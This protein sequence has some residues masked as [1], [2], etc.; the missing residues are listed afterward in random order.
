MTDSWEHDRNLLTGVLALQMGH[1]SRDELLK[2][3]VVWSG[4]RPRP[5][6]AILIE[7]GALQPDKLPS[8]VEA[9]D[10]LMGQNRDDRARI[11][12]TLNYEVVESI[13]EVL[14]TVV[15]P[16]LQA[17]LTRL[18]QR[19]DDTSAKDM[20]ATT[21][22][23]PGTTERNGPST[24]NQNAGPS[25]E[26]RCRFE[27]RSLLKR[28]G[29]GEVY[30]AFDHELGR[31]VALKEIQP[32]KA[33]GTRARDRFI[34]ESEICA[35]LEHPNIVPVYGRGAYPDGTLYYAMRFV[36]GEELQD[37]LDRFHREA[38]GKTPAWWLAEVRPLL[39]SFVQVCEA[40]QYAHS[41][42]VL[43][44]DLKP[45]NVL[46]A[47]FGETLII[48]WGLAKIRGHADLP[49]DTPASEGQ[50]GDSHASSTHVEN[51][52]VLQSSTAALT[53]TEDGELLGSPPYMSPE[54]ALGHHDQLTSATDIYSLGVTLYTVLV[55]HQAF[56]GKN[57][58]EVQ[59]LVARGEYKQAR[60][61]NPLVPKALSEICRKAMAMRPEDRYPT[62]QALARDIE[63]WLGDQP[64]SVH[65]DPFSTKALRWA[66]HHKMATGGSLA[67][68]V[69]VFIALLVAN[70]FVGQ[71]KTRAERARDR[72]LVARNLAGGSAELGLDVVDQLVTLGDRQLINQVPINQ[73]EGFLTKAVS[74]LK[75]YRAFEPTGHES[76]IKTALVA[77]RLANLYRLSGQ[78]DLAQPLY[79]QDVQICEDLVERDPRSARYRD[80][81]A[82]ALLEQAEAHNLA[83]KLEEADREAT[84]A[85]GLA[86]ADLRAD[87]GNSA[88]VRTAARALKQLAA[89]A[90]K[91]SPAK[92]ASLAAEAEATLGPLARTEGGDLRAKTQ[93]SQNLPLVD[94]LILVATRVLRATALES[95]GYLTEAEKELGEA[96][97][98]I[99]GVADDLKGLNIGDVA[100]QR[101]RVASARG[102]LLT[103]MGQAKEAV[104]LLDEAVEGLEGLVAKGGLP[105]H[106][107]GAA[108]AY[109]QR[110]QA[111]LKTGDIEGA[112]ADLKT[113]EDQ[114]TAMCRN[115]AKAIEPRLLL[116]SVLEVIADQTDERDQARERLSEALVAL[117]EVVR[118]SPDLKIARERCAAIEAK[119]G[120]K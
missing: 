45:S 120:P 99:D 44:R 51:P 39:R 73:R 10:R 3:L 29:L 20:A 9:V 69:T 41:R 95:D 117:S 104:I 30:L 101:A 97:S 79:E 98:L 91:V 18:S 114:L 43:H 6:S 103:E 57:R 22:W 40:I 13:Q 72:A 92:A 2:S 113:A 94:Q 7:Q 60:E 37:A 109:F 21:A 119:I 35:N 34:R 55:G 15:D 26:S 74:F 56:R 70:Y 42:D 85:L 8:I 100:F 5:L 27:K 53:R 14:R 88:P 108:E 50:A 17:D 75:S 83:G 58:P 38:K 25:T 16:E 49:S 4:D 66:R 23:G 102:R 32:A 111:R 105:S 24:A 36:L 31:E 77:R 33:G 90:L 106:R 115:M 112:K 52:L 81:L 82:E 116:A 76:L 62:A 93:A 64:V 12:A 48:D 63:R 87:K 71:E 110:A 61:A 28:G 107:Q 96:F 118:L 19:D 47:K 46:L 67:L 54:Q 84:R 86:T 68:V 78:Y 89:Q 59:A 65:E 1:V 80:L 11:G